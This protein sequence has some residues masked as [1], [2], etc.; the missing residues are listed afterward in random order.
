MANTGHKYDR[1][2]KIQAIRLAEEMGSTAKA[3]SELGIPKDTLY[4]W[5]RAVRN[6]TLD[7]GFG[8]HEPRTALTLNEEL[9][10][11]RKKNKAL[12]KEINRIKKENAFLEEASAFFAA[13]RQRSQ[14]NQEWN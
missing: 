8:A 1:D 7:I 12:E 3:A 9:I 13:S 2:Y 14:K 11:L 6:G 4:G 5:V 10:E